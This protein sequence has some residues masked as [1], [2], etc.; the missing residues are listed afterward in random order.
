MWASSNIGRA[1]WSLPCSTANRFAL[2]WVLGHGEDLH[3]GIWQPAR[4]Q[5]RRHLL[6]RLGAAAR[7]QRGV[8]LDQFAI[9]LSECGLVRAQFARVP[10]HAS[11]PR[12]KDSEPALHGLARHRRSPVA[13]DRAA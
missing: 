3:I 9:E 8:C 11:H 1:D 7:G 13:I 6:R 4:A 5:S 12:N 10:G 2:A